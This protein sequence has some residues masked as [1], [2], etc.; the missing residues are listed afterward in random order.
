MISPIGRWA[1]IGNDG[2]GV[3]RRYRPIHTVDFEFLFKNW[4]E[5]ILGSSYSKINF[6]LGFSFLNFSLQNWNWNPRNSSWFDSN[7][8]DFGSKNG[9]L[10]QCS[11]IQSGGEMGGGGWGWSSEAATIGLF[12]VCTACMVG[13]SMYRR[14]F[15]VFLFLSNA[16][17]PDYDKDIQDGQ[18]DYGSQPQQGFADP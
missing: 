7:E 6:N 2:G 8:E 5:K 17:E 13:G 16:V 1:T 10:P 15:Q 9:I 18:G 14:S 4:Q 12:M 11:T 3:D